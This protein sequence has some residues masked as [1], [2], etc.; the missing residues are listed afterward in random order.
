ML[1]RP[2]NDARRPCDVE[3][4]V[5]DPTKAE[6]SVQTLGPWQAE[7]TKRACYLRKVQQ[8]AR[9][10]ATKHLHRQIQSDRSVAFHVNA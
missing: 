10:H 2:R 4:E 8:R 6:D 3:I 7:S 1:P 5:E 9:L